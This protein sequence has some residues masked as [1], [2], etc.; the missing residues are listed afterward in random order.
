MKLRTALRDYKERRGS[1]TAFPGERRS[2]AGIFSGLD[3]RLVHVGPDGSLRDFSYP[4]TG[5]GGIEHLRFGLHT[6]DDIRWFDEYDAERQE[7]VDDTAIVETERTID[8][9]TVVQRDLTLGD[10]HVTNVAVDDETVDAVCVSATF[11]PDDTGAQLAQ[12]DH[13]DAVEV[14]HRKEHDF[15]SAST[16]FDEIMGQVPEQIDEVLSEDD[17]VTF[18][19]IVDDGRYEENKLGGTV[20]A[21]APLGDDGDVTFATLLTSVDEVDRPEALDRTR[22][23]AT[24]HDADAI[25]RA[26]VR[27]RPNWDTGLS[28]DCGA[29]D[30]LRVLS[31]LSCESG[32]RIAGPDFDPMYA[33][34]GGYGYTWFRDDGEIARFLLEA[35]ERTDLDL[36]GFHEASAQFYADTQRPDGTWPHRVWPDDGEIAPGWAHGR[37]ES[38]D[39]ADYQADQTGSVAAFLATYLRLGEPDD[40]A[41]VEATIERALDGLEATTDDDGLPQTA[42]NAWENMTGQFAHTAATFLHAYAAIARAPVDDAL[43]E[44][45][46]EGANAVYEAVDQLWMD[47]RGAYAL[48]LD[49]DELDERLDSSALALADAH[50]EYAAVDDIDDERVERLISHVETTIDGLYRDPDDSD[51]RGVVRFEDDPWRRREQADEKI[52]TVSTAWAA[53][54]ATKLGALLEEYDHDAAGDAFDRAVDLLDVIAPD[55]PLCLDSGYLPEQLFDDGTPDSA[56]PLGWPHALRL[57]TDTELRACDSIADEEPV[58]A[59][60]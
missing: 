45:A 23:L 11:S 7:Y 25:E 52:W 48:R 37:L 10:G 19:R 41:Q 59:D 1:E 9:T 43:A 47:D 15:L 13:G 24:D 49:D 53:N 32:A 16:G 39:G 5:F 27:Q 58:L 31:L 51:V 42:Q 28:G 18:P 55:G 29:T 33:Y 12:L 14:F 21:V 17:P 46:R 34:S 56:T 30:D 20:Y 50:R 54:A 40:P 3:D 8:G 38:T 4:L 36:G 57:A 2:T 60:D 6:G 26:G 22:S 44:R 35:D